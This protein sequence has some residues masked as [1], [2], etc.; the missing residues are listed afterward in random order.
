MPARSDLGESTLAL[1]RAGD[2]SYT[3]Q[4]ANLSLDGAWQVTVLVQRGAQSVEVPLTLQT[5]LLPVVV[6]KLKTPGLPTLYT[7]DL[8]QG[9]TVQVYLDPDR[10]GPVIFHA[11]Y[12]DAKQGALDVTR[13]SITM[14][15]PGGSTTP[16][17][18]RQLDV[19]HFVADATVGKGAYRF[20]ITGTTASGETLTTHLD[21]TAGS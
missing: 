11:T 6:H 21:I 16:L 7:V 14:T 1:T 19:G 17:A 8:T 15:P 4:G 10:P 5:R 3:G 13:C 20:D 9:R 2:G 18:T 12:F